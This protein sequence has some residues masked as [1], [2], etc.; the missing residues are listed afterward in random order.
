MFVVV[1]TL[2]VVKTLGIPAEYMNDLTKKRF[3]YMF[4]YNVGAICSLECVKAG[5]FANNLALH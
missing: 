1:A 2:K 3:V 4:S 5:L